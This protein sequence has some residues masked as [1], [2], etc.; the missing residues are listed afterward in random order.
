MNFAVIGGDMRSVHLCRLLRKDGANVSTFALDQ[1]LPDCP[2]EVE[3]AFL[4]ADA[5]ILPLPCIKGDELNAPF[6]PRR[7]SILSILSAA[8]AGLPI[9]AG[10]ADKI[11]GLCEALRLPLFDYFKREELTVRNAALTAEGAVEL[12]LRSSGRSLCG[13]HVLIC[14]F[15]RIGRILSLRLLAMGAHITAAARSHSDL[16]WAVALGCDTL[17]LGSDRPAAQYDFVVNTIPCTLFGES[18]LESFG[19]A[20]LL[21]LASPPYGFDAAAA[22]KLE[23][24]IIYAPGLPGLTAPETAAAIVRDTIYN[25]IDERSHQ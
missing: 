13:R 11:A 20:I 15:G 18:Y 19:D 21:E 2:A 25:I 23:K 22:R 8:P 7:H 5:A 17:H 10:Q 1:K 14:G 4:N 24:N 6:S 3:E 9:Y 12:M 16:A